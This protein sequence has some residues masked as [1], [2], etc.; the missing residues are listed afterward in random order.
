MDKCIQF[1]FLVVLRL[2]RL[3]SFASGRRRSIG[4]QIFGILEFLCCLLFLPF[5]IHGLS[6][7]RD[8]SAVLAN[9]RHV[10]DNL[11]F[12]TQGTGRH[13]CVGFFI[14]LLPSTFVPYVPIRNPPANNAI[15]LRPIMLCTSV[16]LYLSCI[17]CTINS[18][19]V[20][21]HALYSQPVFMVIVR[22]RPLVSRSQSVLTCCCRSLGFLLEVSH[23]VS[24]LLRLGAFCRLIYK[25]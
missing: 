21:Q 20:L 7:G 19:P 17:I 5:F 9:Y 25:K 18:I 4:D 2:F 23:L 10:F 8:V 1:S 15:F 24:A 6:I 22:I 12:Q 16:L 13:A 14:G 3:P 11:I